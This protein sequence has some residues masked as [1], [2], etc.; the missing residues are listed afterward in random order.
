MIH[1][2][3]KSAC[4][5]FAFWNNIS[6][7]RQDAKILLFFFNLDMYLTVLIV[8]TTLKKMPEINNYS[9]LQDQ[10]LVEWE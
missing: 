2:A 4:V 9:T 7:M 3:W 5:I 8:S 6:F 10:F 1:A